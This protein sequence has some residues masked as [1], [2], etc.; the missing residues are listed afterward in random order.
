[1]IAR[2][3]LRRWGR[4]LTRELLR[5]RLPGG[6]M[7]PCYLG[8]SQDPRARL[9]RQFWWHSGQHWPRGLWL[10]VQVLLWLRWQFLHLV[11]HTL[12]VVKRVGP[13]IAAH[14]GISLACQARRLLWLGLAWC[15]PAS[16]AYAFRLYR[17]PQRA[18]D[19]VYRQETG[20]YHAWRNHARGVYASSLQRM[21]DK[22]ALADWLSAHGVPMV[23]TLARP[24]REATPTLSELLGDTPRAFCKTNSGNQGRGAFA[25]WRSH[26]GLQG[27]L[28][29]GQE[30]VD[31]EAVE[32][33][34]R[35]LCALDQ[36]LIQPCLLDHPLLAP[37]SISPEEII[38]VR[39]ITTWSSG[40]DST[41]QTL[42]AFLEIPAGRRDKGETLYVIL[43]IEP[44][45][46]RVGPPIRSVH[47]S[48][49]YEQALA[50]IELQQQRLGELPYWA[51]VV[52]HSLHAQQLFPDIASI[53]WDWV[54]TPS[55]PV[56][57]EGNSGWGLS[58]VQG[59]R[60]GVL[61][62]EGSSRDH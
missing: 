62:A 4:V 61:A 29:T 3:A 40:R 26:T 15:I 16:E 48:G 6:L 28:F 30:L 27:R 50:R 44:H 8:S 36:S 59:Q 12:R 54:L 37:L 49:L 43:P 46:G 5:R 11:P 58:A 57:L 39:L 60:G 7:S 55:G 41:P 34:W 53:A 14:E 52:S 23:P 17:D 18:L 1:M 25:V 31:S 38:T 33:A 51:S 19:Y 13:S 45:Q 35:A 32:A 2:P 9:H 22:T 24:A 47:W 42:D 20:A 21:Q 56:L 10:V